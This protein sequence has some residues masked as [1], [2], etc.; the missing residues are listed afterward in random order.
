[1]TEKTEKTEQTEKTEKSKKSIISDKKAK[2][3]ISTNKTSFPKNMP[4]FKPM[5]RK[6]GKRG[7]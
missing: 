1:M 3:P 2:A 4:P 5:M 7:T 6:Q